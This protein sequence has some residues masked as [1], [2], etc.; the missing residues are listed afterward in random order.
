MRNNKIR[1]DIQMGLKD[2]VHSVEK[3]QKEYIG[4]FNKKTSVHLIKEIRAVM[5][6]VNAFFDYLKLYKERD[7]EIILDVGCGKGLAFPHI[8]W[9]EFNYFGVDFIPDLLEVC[10]LTHIPSKWFDLEGSDYYKLG[11]YDH[12]FCRNIF[13]YLNKPKWVLDKLVDNLM[14]GGLIMIQ[15]STVMS[16]LSLGIPNKKLEILCQDSPKNLGIEYAEDSKIIIL[17]KK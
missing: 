11:I 13:E 2:K 16:E 15:M 7:D 5:T 1:G 14:P 6:S 8:K 12:L 3:R 9:L 4:R 10:R 17:R